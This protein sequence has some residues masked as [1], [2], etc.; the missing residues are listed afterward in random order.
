MTAVHLNYKVMGQGEPLIVMH[1][2]FGSWENLGS[3]ARGMMDTYQVH[4]LDMRNHGR[5]PH[6][7]NM[8]YS[9]MAAD[10]I[11]YMDD[12]GLEAAHLLGHSM[13]GKVAMTCALT[14]PQ[15][16]RSVLVA[17]IAPVQYERHHERILE[18]LERIDLVAL[19]SRQ[20]ADELLTPYVPEVAVRQFL[21]K[22]LIKANASGFAWRLNLAAIIS[23]YEHIMSGQ[24]STGAFPGPVLF[25][26]GGISDYI[27]PQHREQVLRL[28]PNAS[29]RTIPGTGHWLHAEKCSLFVQ[30]CKR[31]LQS[32]Q[33]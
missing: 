28:F 5:S 3:V 27:L 16:I 18:G 23:N 22:N 2:L 29:M 17:D 8:C 24:S 4:A 32:A 26:K 7:N 30:I 9:L 11:Q 14:Y 20:E 25:I 6:S 15:R 13:G 31:F 1:G 33:K 12:Q 10:V 21:L 19:K